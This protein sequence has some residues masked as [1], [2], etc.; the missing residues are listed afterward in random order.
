VKFG[1]ECDAFDAGDAFAQR[2]ECRVVF[3]ERDFGRR[4]DVVQGLDSFGSRCSA[5]SGCSWW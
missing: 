4:F 5:C 3:D 2:K 1:V